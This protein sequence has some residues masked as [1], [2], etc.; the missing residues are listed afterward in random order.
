MA[1]HLHTIELD[2]DDPRRVFTRPAQA[3][4][5][6]GRPATYRVARVMVYNDGGVWIWAEQLT[7]SGRPYKSGM[8]LTLGSEDRLAEIYGQDVADV[9]AETLA[10]YRRQP[11]S[12]VV[13][14]EDQT[15]RDLTVHRDVDAALDATGVDR[16]FR[17]VIVADLVR[18]GVA[19]TRSTAG[20]RYDVRVVTRATA[21]ALVGATGR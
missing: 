2:A 14:V 11:E 5:N 13:V 1:H 9:V 10:A 6:G 15:T 7:R 4:I 18:D 20:R 16:R 3:G 8:G 19:V 21:D 12:P 17:Y